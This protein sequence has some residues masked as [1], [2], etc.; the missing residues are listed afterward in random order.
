MLFNDV[1]SAIGGTPLVKIDHGQADS[2]EIYAKLE[3][4][5]PG[6]SVKDRPVKYILDELFAKGELAKG[7]IIVESTS[8]NTGIA[9]AMLGATMGLKVIITMPET[10]SVERRELMSAYGAEIV[11]TPG[12]E[13]MKGA[14]E[15]AE[16]IA[17][18]N[19]APILGQFIRK[20][21]VKAHEETTGPEILR[22]LPDVDGFVAGI[23]TGGT[24]TG[25]GH[26]LK[27]HNDK[28]KIWTVEPSESP[29]LTS[30]KAGSHKIQGLGANFVP[31]ILDQEVIDQI[32]LVD[33]ADAIAQARELAREYGILA[34]FSSGANYIVAKRLAKNLGAGKKV[35]VVFPD[36]GE[37]YLS[38]GV[39]GNDGAE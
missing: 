30:G 33:S 14:G 34:G 21:N 31:E 15:K 10:M 4:R 22:D 5:N 9:L 27:A 2:A 24:V 11:L 38:S 13:G 39:Y 29:L 16:A 1:K 6:G 8:G 26:V 28:I 37:R 18:E 35:V 36:T 23:G 17:R 3:A 20:A 32:E 12:K 25:V 7:D 19:N